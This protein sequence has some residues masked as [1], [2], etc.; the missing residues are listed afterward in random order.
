M[1]VLQFVSIFNITQKQVISYRL[2]FIDCILYHANFHIQF[3][4]WTWYFSGLVEIHGDFYIWLLYVML[5]IWMVKG[6]NV[7]WKQSPGR[8]T[9][10]MACPA[11]VS[12]EL[13]C[14]WLP[15]FFGADLPSYSSGKCPSGIGKWYATWLQHNDVAAQGLMETERRRHQPSDESAA[16][17]LQAAPV[18]AGQQVLLK[19]R[20]KL[21]KCAPCFLQ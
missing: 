9:V 21:R 10:A 13:S 1:K 17:G 18:P 5:S 16:A 15:L 3:V 4:L 2:F 20:C 6:Q 7:P 8:I 12:F 19:M 11:G 14:I